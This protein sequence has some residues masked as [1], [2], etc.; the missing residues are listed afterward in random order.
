M[1]VDE[2]EVS[3]L[4][5]RRRSAVRRH[6]AAVKRR[7]VI[8]RIRGLEE[9]IEKIEE[10]STLRASF[11]A[12]LESWRGKL[13]T[14]DEIYQARGLINA[15]PE[16]IDRRGIAERRGNPPP[17]SL[18]SKLL[19][20]QP[21]M[22]GLV[23]NDAFASCAHS[24]ALATLYASSS[25]GEMYAVQTYPQN[26]KSLALL[27]ILVLC[28]FTFTLVSIGEAQAQE[29]LTQAAQRPMAEGEAERSEILDG[30]GADQVAVET[31]LDETESVG[32][33]MS[34]A[35]P[36]GQSLSSPVGPALPASKSEPAPQQYA[37]VIR[38]GEVAETDPDF[39]PA[40][41]KAQPA[42]APKLSDRPSPGKQAEAE[43]KKPAPTPES[44]AQEPYGGSSEMEV[45]A[46]PV[47]E[48][49]PPTA[50]SVSEGEGVPTGSPAPSPIEEDPDAGIAP[51][52]PSAL[53]EPVEQQAP[54]AAD[55]VA[56]PASS[57]TPDQATPPPAQEGAQQPLPISSSVETAS[58]GAAQD[59]LTQTL[60]TVADAAASALE[61]LGSWT[62]YSPSGETTK[63]PSQGATPAPLHPQLPSRLKVAPSS[64]PTRASLARAV[65]GA[66]S[67]CCC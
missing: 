51:P 5:A 31:S 8:R 6:L 23:K 7:A 48:H 43:P 32:S 29:R 55:L 62:D 39:L 52:S 58:S 18:G 60:T 64:S 11:E 47:S 36:P 38:N 16:G 57:R 9:E 1:V 65:P 66:A 53:I 46:A 56:A 44:A 2:V 27:A 61:T 22:L 50:P 26:L 33:T 21:R 25:G 4:L 42:P 63:S 17:S 19:T 54:S 12:A 40:P 10:G 30:K 20:R 67:S 14:Y 34:E 37:V 24:D 35:S 28:L 49:V 15:L 45:P 13:A 41:Q 59:N 3:A